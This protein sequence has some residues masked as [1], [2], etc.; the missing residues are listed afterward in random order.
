MA[1]PKMTSKKTKGTKLAVHAPPKP[2]PATIPSGMVSIAPA[3]DDAS[4]MHPGFGLDAKRILN[5]YQQAE[6]GFPAMQCDLFD[7]VTE[8]DG[9][10]RSAKEQRVEY[11]TG[12]PM[13]LQPGGDAPID[14]EAAR[15]LES[16]LL[17]APN[18][19]ELLDHLF[20]DTFYGYS[21]AETQWTMQDGLYAPAWFSCAPHRRF[22]FDR[23]TDEMRFVTKEAPL[24]IEMERARWIVSR[25]PGRMSAG[26]KVSARFVA[27]MTLTLVD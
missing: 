15:E 17:E 27:M 26:S 23:D 22:V 14:I 3:W 10:L 12:R 18:F 8:R 9:N 16:R 25:R 5:A 13:M 21:A 2:L 4:V 7:D 19:D 24:G 11:V 1:K 20:S 6:A